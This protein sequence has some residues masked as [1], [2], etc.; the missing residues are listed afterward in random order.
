MEY[1]VMCALRTCRSDDSALESAS[2]RCVQALR[3]LSL[4]GGMTRAAGDTAPSRRRSHG[5][6]R[7]RISYLGRTRGPHGIT[8][9]GFQLASIPG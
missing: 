8:Y 9:P 1:A 7:R 6:H 5:I 3:Q 2:R 4:L